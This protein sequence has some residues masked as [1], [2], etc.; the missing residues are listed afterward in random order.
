MGEE[1]LTRTEHEKIFIGQPLDMDIT[2]I[3]RKLASLRE[4]IQDEHHSYEEIKNKMK[5]AVPTFH[6]PK[7]VNEKVK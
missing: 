7:E 1:G 3:E 6:E 2:E 4:L 5:K